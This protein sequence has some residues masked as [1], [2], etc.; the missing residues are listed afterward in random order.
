M[1]EIEEL[2]KNKT[3]IKFRGSSFWMLHSIVDRLLK[4]GKLSFSVKLLQL[5]FSS[6]LAQLPKFPYSPA[7]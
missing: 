2:V 6:F 1:L 3:L 7:F 4:L 5:V